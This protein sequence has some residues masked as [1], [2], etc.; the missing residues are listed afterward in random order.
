MP[1]SKPD[2]RKTFPA[3]HS[4][5]TPRQTASKDK[6][7]PARS[8]YNNS[9]RTRSKRPRPAAVH[10]PPTCPCAYWRILPGIATAEKRKTLWDQ[11]MRGEYVG[12]PTHFRS[13]R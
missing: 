6:W 1:I 3:S 8:A 11:P 2:R 4:N 10:P 7:I 13:T 12:L 5:A 9:P